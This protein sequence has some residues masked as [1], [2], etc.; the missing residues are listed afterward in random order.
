MTRSSAGGNRAGRYSS[1]QNSIVEECC[2]VFSVTLTLSVT[3]LFFLPF[4]SFLSVSLIF[5]FFSHLPFR[6]FP[7]L[8]CVLSQSSLSALITRTERHK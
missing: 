4:T 7:F 3:H 1:G 2:V 5:L 8:Q 6:Q